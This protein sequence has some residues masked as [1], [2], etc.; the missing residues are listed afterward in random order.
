MHILTARSDSGEERSKG[1]GIGVKTMYIDCLVWTE[2]VGSGLM[3]ANG[4]T[5]R[6]RLLR[7]TRIRTLRIVARVK[8]KHIDCKVG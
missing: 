5:T 6:Y 1:R 2:E 3:G 8:N 4:K 7:V